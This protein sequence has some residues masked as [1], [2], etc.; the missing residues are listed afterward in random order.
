[1]N[2]RKKT[3][4]TGKEFVQGLGLAIAKRRLR[5]RLTQNELSTLAGV[6]RGYLS[7]VETGRRDNITVLTLLRLSESL[8]IAPT[9]LIVMVEK[10]KRQ[11]SNLRTR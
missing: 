3:Q 7:D 4:E 9:K 8:Q 6:R 10:S 5:L 2:R 11:E 1:M